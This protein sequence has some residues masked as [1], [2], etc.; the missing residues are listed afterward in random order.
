M[1]N[2]KKALALFV[3]AASVF[4]TIASAELSFLNPVTNQLDLIT[5]TPSGA[6]VWQGNGRVDTSVYDYSIVDGALVMKTKDSITDFSGG[7]KMSMGYALNSTGVFDQTGNAL[8]RSSFGKTKVVLEFSLKP[9]SNTN[10]TLGTVFNGD[11]GEI[12]IMAVNYTTSSGETTQEVVTTGLKWH[13]PNADG[14]YAIKFSDYIKEDNHWNHGEHKLRLTGEFDPA[15]M[16]ITLSMVDTENNAVIFNSQKT[17]P[18]GATFKFVRPCLYMRTRAATAPILYKYEYTGESAE[19]ENSAIDATGTN[20][21]ASVDVYGNLDTGIPNGIKNKPVVAILAQYDANDHF[22]GCTSDSG[23]YQVLGT[24]ADA[25]AGRRADAK[26]LTPSMA[27]DANYAYAK[28]FV[29]DSSNTMNPLA[30]VYSNK[31]N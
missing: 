17:L 4:G 20:L 15:T 26:T 19:T 23:E 2:L 1:K 6:Q 14:T 8:R 28:L 5:A 24:N 3:A 11:K 31:V 7:G 21:N 13:S 29:W 25:A 10:Y 22:I 12:K 30:E 18:E 27:K 9:T 16:K